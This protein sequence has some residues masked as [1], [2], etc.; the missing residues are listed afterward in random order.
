MQ[1]ISGG[2]GAGGYTT[3]VGVY[4]SYL[5]KLDRWC[6]LIKTQKGNLEVTQPWTTNEYLLDMTSGQFSNSGPTADAPL[7]SGGGS[8]GMILSGPQG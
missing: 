2:G 1:I 3:G 4:D 8:T 6:Q 5:V 7:G